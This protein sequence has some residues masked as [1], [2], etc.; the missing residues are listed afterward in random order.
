LKLDLPWIEDVQ[1][2]KK[3]LRLPVVLIRQEVM[4]TYRRR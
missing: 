1:R 3:P 2:A 4:P